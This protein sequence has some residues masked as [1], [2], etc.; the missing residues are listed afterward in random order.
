[1]K[2]RPDTQNGNR[3]AYAVGYRQPPEGSRFRAGQSGNPK[4]RPKGARNRTTI[5]DHALNERVVV[6]D[7][8]KRKSITKQEA[9]FKQLVNKAASGDYRAAQ[10]VL[11]EMRE[12]EAR[13]SSTESGR[14]IIDQ[15]DQQ[16][17]ENFVK[18]LG[19]LEVE[20][21]NN[22]DSNRG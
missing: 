11:N 13:L 10:L 14:E 6:T 8:G 1:M 22:D 20:D 9:I 7:N 17:F 12:L 18:R 4:G 19:Q 3:P 16:V 2:K 5:L 21:G 15:A